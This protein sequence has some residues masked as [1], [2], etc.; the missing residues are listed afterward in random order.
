M[1]TR[2]WAILLA[3]WH[4]IHPRSIAILAFSIVDWAAGRNRGLNSSALLRLTRQMS[5]L[6]MACNNQLRG[7]CTSI[8]TSV[9]DQDWIGKTGTNEGFDVVKIHGTNI[10]SPGSIISRQCPHSVGDAAQGH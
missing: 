3:A 5:T 4:P 10:G 8:L 2:S 7:F 1:L 6:S 9:P